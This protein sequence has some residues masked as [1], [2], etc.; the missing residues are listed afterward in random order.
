MSLVVDATF[1]GFISLLIGQAVGDSSI[2]ETLRRMQELQ[3]GQGPA[4]AN[5]YHHSPGNPVHVTNASNDNNRK[6]LRRRRARTEAPHRCQQVPRHGCSI[7]GPG[8]CVGNSHALLSLPGQPGMTCGFVQHTGYMGRLSEDHCNGNLLGLID[9]CECADGTP[10][11]TTGTPLTTAPSLPQTDNP[12]IELS[13]STTGRMNH[14]APVPVS[15]TRGISLA[16]SVADNVPSSHAARNPDLL[17]IVQELLLSGTNKADAVI[18]TSQE[19]ACPQVLNYG[20]SI[21]GTNRCVGNPAATFSF[22]GKPSTTCGQLETAGYQ[23]QIPIDQCSFLPELIPLCECGYSAPRNSV[24]T[25]E[26]GV[27]SVWQ[28]TRVQSPTHSSSP[29]QGL[30]DVESADKYTASDDDT[31]IDLFANPDLAN[32]QGTENVEHP[33]ASETNDF[34]P[35]GF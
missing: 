11:T 4:I 6:Q 27:G 8:L 20:C 34:E 12:T 1:L 32:F 21:C 13:S 33:N 9:V 16:Q 15:S 26:E 18:T 31:Y 25:S 28:P 35:N 14:D 24:S 22:P 2:S 3:F 30:D 23:G 7:C 29:A 5:A 17:S 10:G 19:G